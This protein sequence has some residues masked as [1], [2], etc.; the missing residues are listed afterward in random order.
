MKRGI[1]WNDP[2]QKRA[3]NREW[4]RNRRKMPRVRIR[5]SAAIRLFPDTYIGSSW[6]AVVRKVLG[7]A[8]APLS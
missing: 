2:A 8:G 1:D 5:K 6:R 3:Y 4:M 7:E